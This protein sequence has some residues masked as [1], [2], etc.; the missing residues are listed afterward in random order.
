[1]AKL[2]DFD[3]LCV[4]QGARVRLARVSTES[5]KLVPSR[6]RADKATQRAVERLAVYQDSLYAE[7]RRSLLHGTVPTERG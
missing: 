2:M 6:D 1:M 3:H 7:G 4:R 5:T